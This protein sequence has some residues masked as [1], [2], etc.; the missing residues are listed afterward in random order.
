LKNAKEI[1]DGLKTAH[2]GDRIT[3]ITK[4]GVIERELRWFTL[5]K[6]EEPQEM[7][8]RLKMMVNQV[9]NLGSS[10]WTDHEVV[11][12][13]LRSLVFCNATLVQL[14][15][16]NPR[17]EVITPKEVLGKFVIFELCSNTPNMWRTSPMATPQHTSHK[18]LASR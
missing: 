3:K 8:N 17:Y 16:E 9:W 14:L 7:Y 15:R 11:K 13:M 12:L 10:K 2:K 5:N 1:W 6:G 4:M 18:S